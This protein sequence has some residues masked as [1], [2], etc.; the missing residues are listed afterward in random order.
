MTWAMVISAA[1]V[2]LSS[3]RPTSTVWPKKACASLK[4]MQEA[5]FLLLHAPA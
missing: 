4:P 1:M 5:L 3:T 2:S